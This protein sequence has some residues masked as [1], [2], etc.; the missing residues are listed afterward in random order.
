MK[1][2]VLGSS[3]HKNGASNTLAGYFIKG[4]QEA[5]HT[6][7]VIDVAHT[8]MEPCRGCY[9]G[10]KMQRCVIYDDFSRI[11]AELENSDMI[12]YVT[13]VYYYLMAAPLKAVIDR[14]HC[15]EPKLHGMKSLLIVTAHRSDD[16]VVQYLQD[17]YKGL[18]DYLEYDDK[19]TIMA[20]G[21]YDTETV[22]NSL[23]AQ[24]AYLLGKSL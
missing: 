23:Y 12:V 18:V 13:P 16:Q 17:F 10:E 21:C 5:G 4:A 7:I 9:V 20:K 6:V 8:K 22:Q 15:F 24:R 14:L 19:G 3:P 2:T 11:E 1:I